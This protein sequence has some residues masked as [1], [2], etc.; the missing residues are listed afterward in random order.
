MDVVCDRCNTEYEFDDALV[1]ERGTTVKCTHC[2]HQFR[3][4]RPKSDGTVARPWILKRSDG[5]TATFDSLAV[6]QRWIAEGKASRADLLSR[7]G[8]DW[9]PLGSIAELE[10]FFAQAEAK[11]RATASSKPSSAAASAQATPP[12]APPRRATTPGMPPAPPPVAPPP[13]PSSGST[14]P[15]GSHVAPPPSNVPSLPAPPMA[16]PTPAQSAVQS[17]PPSVAKQ[18][19]PPSAPAAPASVGPSSYSLGGAENELTTEAYDF[20][21]DT[22]IMEK[23]GADGKP[24][25]AKPAVGPPPISPRATSSSAPE[26]T[27]I[28]D[29]EP[30]RA[31]KTAAKPL[32]GKGT[33]IGGVLVA[34]LAGGAIAAWQAGVLSSGNRGATAAQDAVSSA[35]ESAETAAKAA[36][37]AGF[38]DAK[39]SLTALLLT[40]ANRNDPRVL[41]ARAAV[42][43]ARGESMRQRAED[44]EARAARGGTDAA[45]VRA[46]ASIIRTG[47]LADIERARTDAAAAEAGA[48]RVTSPAD[49]GRFE[50]ALAEIARVVRGDLASA[51]Q[52]AAAAKTAGA[53]T[54]L[55]DGLIAR[56]AGEFDVAV[57]SLRRAAEASDADSRARLALARLYA[58]RGDRAGAVEQ[59]T[60]LL[61]VRPQHDEAQ[62][63]QTAIE[64]G[65][66]PLREGGA[67][68]QAGVDAGSVAVVRPAVNVVVDSGVLVAQVGA[69]ADSSGATQGSV[70]GSG[71]GSSSGPF[72]G[73]SYDWL[74]EE[75]ERQ[76]ARGQTER[77]RSAF[78]A[79]LALR[80]DG[81]EA[82]TG[83]GFVEMRSGEIGAAV[84]LFRRA[85]GLNSRYSDAYIGLGQAYERQSNIEQALRAYRQYLEINPG[86]SRAREAQARVDALDRSANSAGSGSSGSSG[87]TGSSGSGSSGG[88]SDGNGSSGSASSAGSSGTSG[89]SGSTGSSSSEGSGGSGSSPTPNP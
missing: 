59:L 76:R 75:G 72:A 50:R 88:S 1:S 42:L 34:M 18:A 15:Y 52:H 27:S 41:A 20:G 22:G 40:P 74:V 12:T 17:A 82:V 31:S 37:R 35:I 65:L 69:G 77:A 32:G 11:L 51:R 2:G 67:V 44:L 33:L 85:I 25:L 38:D 47:A 8:V 26:A 6:L 80:G 55:I 79:A 24:K 84:L 68:A 58:A 63:M 86:G 28:V 56:D 89:S 64:A 23:W 13:R 57:A 10:G 53:N 48:A 21:D 16:P 45:T 60:A 43:A 46:E 49:R 30:P 54:D 19:T 70:T 3:I 4:F 39:E 78:M 14:A 73:R 71:G 81:C 9:K 66:P 5:K 7:D 87:S 61:R 83:L 62:A 36:T 29:D